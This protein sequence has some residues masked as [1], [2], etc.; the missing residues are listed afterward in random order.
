MQIENLTLALNSAQSIGCNVINI[1]AHDLI[2]GKQ[3]LV[4]GLLWQ[5]IRIGL[6]NQITLEH[7]P[8]LVRLLKE[9]EEMQEL[10]QLSPETI[11]IRWVNYHLENAGV[12]RRLNNFTSDI[13]DSIIYT[14]LL[15]QI[16]P[17]GTNLT[18]EPLFETNVLKRAELMLQQ[19]EQLG[20]RSFVSAADVVNG[21]YKLNVAFVANLFNKHPGL[22]KPEEP[23]QIENV[24]EDREEKT[25]R[26]W[27]NSM[28]V[29]PYVNWLYSDLAD[30]L[31]I[32]Q[33]YDVITPGI[34]NW[35]RVHRQFNRM[36]K[37]MEKLENCNYAVELGKQ[38][39]F[40]L[41]GIGG[42]DISE[43]NPTLTL[44]LVWQL[45]RSYT[46]NML[47]GLTSSQDGKPVAEKEIVDWVNQKLAS[48]GKSTSIRNFQDKEI[49]SAMPVIDLIDAIK[50]GSI[51]Y[52]QM[53]E[54]T[55]PEVRTFAILFVLFYFIFSF[56]KSI[57]TILAFFNLKG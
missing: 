17:Q 19:A 6:F 49:S 29:N 9:G 48:A 32:F 15:Q 40:R 1:D 5:I 31:V 8:G 42:N 54:A 53:L 23:I 7:C 35:S 30:G 28:G 18:T 16:Q 4:L 34:V 25:Y 21:V 41:V 52:S 46:L 43:G 20:C 51:N 33:L 38:C 2:K 3:H 24:E 36:K 56:T 27:M 57:L 13:N 11:L 47:K 50:P 14:H 22:D 12:N 10:T 55:T 26:N 37:F 44:A 45:M 39:G